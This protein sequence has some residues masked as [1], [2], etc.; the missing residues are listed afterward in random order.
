[1]FESDVKLANGIS[2]HYVDSG[3]SPNKQQQTVVFVHGWPDFS[4]SWNKQ[5]TFLSKLNYRVICPDLPGFGQSS[6][7]EQ[8]EAYTFK[9]I[10]KYLA[11]L[12]DH[13][14]IQKAVFVGH[15]WGGVVVW[16]MALWFPERVEAVAAICTP[17]APRSPTFIPLERL[18]ERKPVFYYQLYFNL[19]NGKVAQ[20]ELEK[21]VERT[22]SCLFR[23]SK[24]EDRIG[25]WMDK[26]SKGLLS[27]FPAKVNRSKL[28]SEVEFSKYVQTFTKSGFRG[29]LNFY[30]TSELNWIDEENLPVNVNHR[31]LM[32]TAGK[33]SVLSP[34]LTRGMENFIPNLRRAHIEESS[35]WVQHE[36]PDLLNSI[37][38]QWLSSLS[39]PSSKL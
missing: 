27:G 30:K 20:N 29:G 32:V 17:Y 21:Y 3:Q 9:N 38:S 24:N 35:H 8:V 5:M 37:L 2:I 18:V 28:L 10:T 1:M 13:L 7:P 12:L 33:D 11:G 19:E 22:I 23:T 39:Q 6:A 4:Y 25:Q 34:E 16:R 36:Q 15:D 14:K 26:N 31:S